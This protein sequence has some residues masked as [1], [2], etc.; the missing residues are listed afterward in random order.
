MVD[1]IKKEAR[2]LIPIMIFI[3]LIFLPDY[4]LGMTLAGLYLLTEHMWSYG[5]WSIKDFLGHEMFG[6]VLLSL[7]LCLMGSWVISTI[8]ILIYLIFGDWGWRDADLPLQHAWNK[9]LSVIGS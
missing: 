8:S 4:A 1:Y 6:I 2:K 5:Y 7:G 3:F 9:I